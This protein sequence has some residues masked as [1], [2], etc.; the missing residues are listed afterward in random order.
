MKRAHCVFYDSPSNG[1]PALAVVFA[2][3]WHVLAAREVRSHQSAEIVFAQLK[4]EILA[5]GSYVFE[6]SDGDDA[7][8]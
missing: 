2:S 1:C 4:R 7:V 6:Q 8:A 3:D 5:M